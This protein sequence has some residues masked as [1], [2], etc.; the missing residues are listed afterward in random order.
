MRAARETR[1]RERRQARESERDCILHSTSTCSA[2]P[3]VERLLSVLKLVV[4]AIGQSMVE[5]TLEAWLFVQ[6]NMVRN[7]IYQSPAS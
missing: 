5:E 7:G 6:N 4:D 1:Q 2:R 3:D